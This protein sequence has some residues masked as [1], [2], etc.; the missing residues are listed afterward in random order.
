MN[1]LV[2]IPLMPAL[3]F[4]LFFLLPRR[5]RTK[6]LFVPLG[7]MAT[8]L[9]LS[10]IAFASVFPG[11]EKIA[12]HGAQ[13]TSYS[14]G[15]IGG[16]PLDISLRLDPLA[17]LMLLVVTIV[18]MA[19]QVYS[20]SYMKGEERIAWYYAVLS[21]FTAAMLTLVL[22]GDF[23]LF[24]MSWEVMGLCS[25]LLIGFWNTNDEAR[26]ASIKAFLTT[27][28]G[29][30]G[31]AISLA[32]I[33]A[34][35]G[36]FD[37]PTVLGAAH[38]WAPG[39]ATAVALL[40]FFGAMGK[41]AQF[42]LHIWLP[43]AMAGPTPASAL[44]HAATMV[45]A[46]VFLVAR[47]LPV[48]EVSGV[49]LQVVLV[50]G[51]ITTLMAASMGAVQHD[52][53]KVLAYSTISQLGYMFLGLGTGIVSAGMFHL[54]TH[55]FFKSL[56]FL[57]AG[58]IIHALH[59]QDMR[60][61]GGVAKDMKVTTAVFTVGTLAL[62]GILPFSGFFSKDLIL[63]HL[64]KEGHY[65]VFSVALITAGLTAFYMSRL[66]FRVFSGTPRGDHRA[67]EAD[68][69]ILLPM[70]VLAVFAAG[71]GAFTIVLGEFLGSETEWPQL[72]MASVS[73]LTALGGIGLG[74]V[75]F[76]NG[77]DPEAARARASKTYMIVTNKFFLDLIAEHYI[78]GGY[79]RLSEKVN[80]F[81]KYIIN[82][83]VNGVGV[84]C[85][86]AGGTL[87]RIQT[88][89]VQTYQRLAIAAFLVLVLVVVLA[90]GV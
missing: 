57:G 13:F 32:M 40:L 59:T 53:K 36:S 43:D 61:M 48:F 5:T 20:L 22:A 69:K 1:I 41:S 50:I 54:F 78:A 52:I 15:V 77:R 24:Y 35:V 90:T 81:D 80:W 70:V 67:H 64:W 39:V 31:F 51:A 33:W 3:V 49:A 74:W 26:K 14:I 28:I 30:V 34:N 87:R 4:L 63:D 10:L 71:A 11:A 75:L 73:T 29:D 83:V 25:Y 19:V 84:A 46:G 89:Q 7:A 18:G 6:L 58:S 82:G 76:G 85:R 27:R 55:A 66:W 86:N 45:A 42:P 16:V 88:G 65:I 8:S 44:I 79:N 60:E 56:L 72:A 38:S 17:A 2:A 12:E 23:L 21:L 62:S 37:I 68:A 47:A 9:V